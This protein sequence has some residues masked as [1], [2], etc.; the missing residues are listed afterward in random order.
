M[1]NFRG[2]KYIFKNVRG[3]FCKIVGTKTKY[4][5]KERGFSAKLHGPRGLLRFVNYFSDEK[6]VK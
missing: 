5:I 1:Q 3:C 4:K 2:E 6:M